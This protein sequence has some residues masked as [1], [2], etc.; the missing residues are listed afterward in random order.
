MMQ[1]WFVLQIQIRLGEGANK[2][3]IRELDLISDLCCGHSRSDKEYPHMPAKC[4][5]SSIWCNWISDILPILPSSDSILVISTYLWLHL[6]EKCK[7]D[8][9][10]V[11]IRFF[12][13]NL[14]CSAHILSPHCNAITEK[15]SAMGCIE[16]MMA[17]QGVERQTGGETVAVSM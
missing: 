7:L 2:R 4:I 5:C 14:E 17:M 1:I 13:S 16:R 9:S 11:Q 12:L 3:K 6:T 10:R 15:F 8:L